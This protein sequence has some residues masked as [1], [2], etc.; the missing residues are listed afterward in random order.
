MPRL[1]RGPREH[2]PTVDTTMRVAHERA[3][4]GAPEGFLV[5]SDEQTAGRGRLGR[6]WVS[7]P[8]DGLYFSILLV[9]LE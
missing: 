6:N 8:G 3:D 2:L 7:R 5:S 1:T 4:A 9:M